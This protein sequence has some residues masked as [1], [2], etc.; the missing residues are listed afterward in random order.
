MISPTTRRL[1]FVMLFVPLLVGLALAVFAWPA[2]NL[3][4]RN[5][6]LGLVG[7]APVTSQVA[8]RLR[9]QSPDAFDLHIYA[10][11]ADARSAIEHRDTYGAIIF[12]P[13]GTTLL[14]TSAGSALVA[15]LLTQELGPALGSQ[16]NGQPLQIIDVVPAAAKDPH[17]LALGASVLPLVLA[18]LL[19]GVLLFLLSRPGWRQIG[20]LLGA[21][22]ISGLV[23]DALV[24]GWL[25]AL[26]GDWLAN[27]GV[28]TLTIVAIASTVAGMGNLFG[29][30][31]IVSGVL[32]MFFLG[33]PFS[34]VTTAPSLLPTAVAVIGQLLPPGAGGNLLRSTAFFGGE[35]AVGSLLVLLAWSVLGLGAMSLAALWQGRKA[36]RTPEMVA[37][38]SPII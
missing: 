34:G 11:E 23:A 12:A 1:I 8:A 7:P 3:A 27:T 10:N 14:I 32:L 16:A 6:P 5:L 28:F 30:V 15:Q 17:G 36:V 31:G 2:V 21:A 19:V 26:N 24:Q 33:N 35:G 37:Q 22:F 25:G 9:A 29:R 18:G 4:P 38:Q 20:S 13:S